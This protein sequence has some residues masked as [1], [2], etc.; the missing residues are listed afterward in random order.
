MSRVPVSTD[1]T[2]NWALTCNYQSGHCLHLSVVSQHVRRQGLQRPD[3]RF[4]PSQNSTATAAYLLQT[5]PCNV[6][7]LLGSPT[8][9]LARPVKEGAV[10]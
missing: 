6:P 7:P 10:R 2:T 4:T 8:M 9:G 3:A 5:A 1:R